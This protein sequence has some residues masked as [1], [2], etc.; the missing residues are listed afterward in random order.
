MAVR[1]NHL[2]F[3]RLVKEP[4]PTATGHAIPYCK[5]LIANVVELEDHGVPFA[6]VDAR[7]ALEVLDQVGRTRE[8]HSGLSSS[9]SVDVALAI[10]RVVLLPVRG[11]ARAAK[12][13]VLTWFTPP[14]EVPRPV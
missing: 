9:G 8:P 5:R 1:A 4:L 13:V 2:A 7:V 12:R 11:A 10:R 3:V 14:G 6:T